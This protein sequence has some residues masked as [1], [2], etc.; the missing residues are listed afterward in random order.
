MIFQFASF[1]M[2]SM[3]FIFYLTN[4]P[5]RL[6]MMKR[7]TVD[8]NTT[9]EAGCSLLRV[10]ALHCMSREHCFLDSNMIFSEAQKFLGDY[11]SRNK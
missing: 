11:T 10:S 7:G 3:Y 8:Q 4:Q 5:S 6:K 9:N 2:K 1:H